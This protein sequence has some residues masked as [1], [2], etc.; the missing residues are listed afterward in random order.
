MKF[1]VVVVVVNVGIAEKKGGKTENIIKCT[2][3]RAHIF[4]FDNNEFLCSVVFIIIIFKSCCFVFDWI[5]P[6]FAGTVSYFQYLGKGNL[7]FG[8]YF[9]SLEFFGMLSRVNTQRSYFCVMF[10]G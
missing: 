10:F 7:S 5:L 8:R 1:F 9:M 2:N 6:A 3:M 4:R